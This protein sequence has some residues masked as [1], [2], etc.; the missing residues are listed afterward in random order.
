M[1]P[2]G[3]IVPDK[4][5]TDERGVKRKIDSEPEWWIYNSLEKYGLRFDYQV[6]QRGGKRHPWGIVVDFVV[7]AGIVTALEH[8]GA[9]WHTG[10]F[11]ENDALKWS[12]LSRVYDRVLLLADEPMPSMGGWVATDVVVDQES[13]DHVI[14][15]H[16]V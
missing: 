3:I 13:S 10:R 6:S 2:D 4:I 12:Y 9:Y 14:R 15:K 7:Y 1:F 8:L 5:I 11:G 16:F